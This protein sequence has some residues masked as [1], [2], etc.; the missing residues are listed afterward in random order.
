M[1]R[2]RTSALV[3]RLRVRLSDGSRFFETGNKASTRNCLA[4]IAVSCLVMIGLC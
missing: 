3:A 1:G 4:A 2:K